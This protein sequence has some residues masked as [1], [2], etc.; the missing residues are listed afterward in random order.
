MLSPCPCLAGPDR[1]TAWK[2]TARIHAVHAVLQ[3][4]SR[5]CSPEVEL[6]GTG[7]ASTD[8][9]HISRSSSSSSSDSSSQHHH[10][11]PACLP[12]Q[13]WSEAVQA[14]QWASGPGGPAGAVRHPP[15]K[16]TTCAGI[17]LPGLPQ[18]AS[19]H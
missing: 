2:L 13:C 11:Q 7:H 18:D 1:L 4:R 3:A 10:Q 14:V 9:K 12:L 15:H 6:C 16:S 19:S 17:C 8:S 5:A